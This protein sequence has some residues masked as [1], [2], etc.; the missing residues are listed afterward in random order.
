MS[1]QISNICR[2]VRYQLRNIGFIRK[3]LSKSATEKIVHALISSRLDFCNALLFN[4]PQNQ[5][6]KLQKLQNA[7]ARV[8]TLSNKRSHITPILNS[9][10]WLPIKHRIIFKILLL[11]FHCIHASAPQYNISFINYYIPKRS[12]RSS[13]SG[14]LVV[15]KV[16][17]TWGERS[18]AYACPTL[19]NSLPEDIKTCS[20]VDSFKC[21]LKTFLF[22]SQ[23]SNSALSTLQS[24]FGA[25]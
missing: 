24:G 6:Y 3:Y 12:L 9:L 19:W 1:P 14:A 7:A 17:R 25:L 8:V 4:L 13:T 10:H 23:V 2:S 18:F 20:S 5:L 21:L 16:S 15:P 11:A 22:S